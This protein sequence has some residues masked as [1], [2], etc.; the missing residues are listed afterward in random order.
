MA[1]PIAIFIKANDKPIEGEVRQRVQAFKGACECRTMHIAARAGQAGGA[2]PA[3][4]V[5]IDD[6]VLV[7]R[8]DCASPLLFAALCKN[9]TISLEAKFVRPAAANGTTEHYYSIVGLRGRI[10][11]IAQSTP[12]AMDPKSS[13]EEPCETICFRF[14][15]ITFKYPPKNLEYSHSPSEGE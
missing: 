10:T 1:E 9:E 5:S 13:S 14:E 2:V 11:S 6:L 12:D 7:K 4:A 15:K 8:I 3:G